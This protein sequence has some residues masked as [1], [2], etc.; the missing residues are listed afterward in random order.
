MRPASRAFALVSLS[1]LCALPAAVTAQE[2]AEPG[3]EL[4][5]DEAARKALA[6][7]TESFQKQ[8]C[9]RARIV[10]EREDLVGKRREEGEMVLQRPDRVLR[11]FGPPG[12][13]VKA[14]RLEGPL[15]LE[16]VPREKGVVPRDFGQA[17]KALA[18]ARAALT[19]DTETLAQ[20]FAIAVFRKP[21]T[22]GRPAQWRL[23]LTRR[24]EKAE[25]PLAPRIQARLEEGAAFFSEIWKA[26]EGADD[27]VVEKYSDL[28]VEKDLTDRDFDEPLLKKDRRE[29]HVVPEIK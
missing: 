21:G 18:L 2:K 27:Y 1:L 13:A 14:L 16:Y 5:K 24:P 19:L 28:R 8:P 20:Y 10:S 23:V 26:G 15:L 3:E 11:R 6:G 9:V 22:E 7:I 25:L 17:P 4:V 12:Q 29:A